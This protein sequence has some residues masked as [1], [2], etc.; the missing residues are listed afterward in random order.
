MSLVPDGQISKWEEAA[1][2]LVEQLR[3]REARTAELKV[4]L[5]TLCEVVERTAF[6]MPPPNEFTPRFVQAVQSARIA[7]H[8]SE[9]N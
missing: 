2:K 5:K 7:L 4:A 6:E 9:E 1:F 8:Q 3:Q